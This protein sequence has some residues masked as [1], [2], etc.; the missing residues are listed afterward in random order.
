ME[1]TG[2]Q[3]TEHLNQQGALFG[4]GQGG[5]IS[6]RPGEG[7]KGKRDRKAQRSFGTSESGGIRLQVLQPKPLIP[8]EARS[9]G[10][11]DILRRPAGES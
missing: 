2:S 6:A 8:E 11:S 7:G 10:I 9:R 5:G 1:R 4:S 3:H